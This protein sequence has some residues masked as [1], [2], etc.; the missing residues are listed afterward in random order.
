MCSGVTL[1]ALDDPP[2]TLDL[3]RPAPAS[4]V[5][6][7]LLDVDHLRAESGGEL[8]RRGEIVARLADVGMGASLGRQVA[9]AV[10]GREAGLEELRRDPGHPLGHDRPTDGRD[11]QRAA[12]LADRR[13]IARRWPR[14]ANRNSVGRPVL[15]W[16][17]GR[18][19]PRS[20]A[21]ASRTVTVDGSSGT[22]RS[23]AS[24]P[25]GTR[26]QLRVDG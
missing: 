14:S 21:Q 11:R 2:V 18:W 16:R 12:D 3:A 10:A 15:G 4:G 6:L 9:R 22:I 24:L 19:R 8:G 1:E 25:S 13:V 23:V 20:A 7:E 5:G 26:S 17:T